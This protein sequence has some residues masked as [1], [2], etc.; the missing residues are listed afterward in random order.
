[1]KEGVLISNFF[2]TYLLAKK[3]HSPKHPN[4]EV[5]KQIIDEN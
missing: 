3:T 5:N 4:G 2:L 1:M